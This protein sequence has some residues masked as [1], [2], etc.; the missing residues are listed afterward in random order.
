M[1]SSHTTSSSTTSSPIE[2]SSAS[3]RNF[4]L[5]RRRLW[6]E[7]FYSFCTTGSDLVVGKITIVDVGVEVG[8]GEIRAD[9]EPTWSNRS[10][11]AKQ[12]QTENFSLI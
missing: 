2:A 12:M 3:A 9:C 6:S 11:S 1:I 7:C 4:T 10:I 8:I 5:G